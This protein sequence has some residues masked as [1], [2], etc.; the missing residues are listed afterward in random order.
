M[1]S[2]LSLFART[3]LFLYSL[4]SV[5]ISSASRGG[6]R[7]L[8]WRHSGL[9]TTVEW[10]QAPFSL[11]PTVLTTSM[12]KSLHLFQTIAAHLASAPSLKICFRRRYVKVLITN[13]WFPSFG[14]LTDDHL[15]DPGRP[16]PEHL[17]VLGVL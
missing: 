13:I 16:S 11:L 6:Q 5:T 15:C 17:R 9:S 14:L 10:S 3:D 7:T 12:A 8:F 2:F 1:V 4:K